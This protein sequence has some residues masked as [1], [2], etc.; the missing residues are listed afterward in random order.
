[1][2]DFPKTDIKHIPKHNISILPNNTAIYSQ[3]INI[4]R[5]IRHKSNRTFTCHNIINIDTK[6]NTA[7]Q[8]QNNIK[9]S[10]SYSSV[11]K[12]TESYLSLINLQRKRKNNKRLTSTLDSTV[13]HI[14]LDDL[15]TNSGTKKNLIFILISFLFKPY[16]RSNEVE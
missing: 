6:N 3:N 2:N 5:N 14:N 11:S 15:S 9:Y 10:D 16:C 8:K 13:P 4:G 7:I 1:M 12:S